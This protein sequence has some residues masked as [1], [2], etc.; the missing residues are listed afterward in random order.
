M[1]LPAV[2]AL[3]AERPA[4]RV[5]VLVKPPLVPFWRMVPGLHA[6]IE[7][8]PSTAGTFWAVSAVRNGRFDRAIV[9]PNSFRS[10][11]I[12]FL[13]GVPIRRGAATHL[14]GWLLT[15]RVAAATVT[16]SARRHQAW[17]YLRLLDVNP[18]AGELAL[19][20]LDPGAAVRATC[21][22]RLPLGAGAPWVGILPGAARGPSKRWPAAHFAEVGR[23][24][25]SECGVRS[26]VFGSPG[27]LDVCREVADG[28]GAAAVC[29]AGRTSLPELTALLAGCRAVVTNDSGGMHLAAASGTI[30]VAVFG[31]TDPAVTGPIGAGHRVLAAPGVHPCRDIPR[32]SAAAAQALR[33]I[34]PDTVFTAAVAALGHTAAGGA[35]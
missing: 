14:R 15:D 31:L 33:A 22:A 16:D 25:A 30:V 26:A 5:S 11:W 1:S 28:I 8:A 3:L 34:A 4:A 7:L 32:V 10:A 35:R 23:R 21:Q 18:P 24:L 29:L 17:E 27:E 20:R 12:P 9:L 19:P 13:A 2:T 6:V